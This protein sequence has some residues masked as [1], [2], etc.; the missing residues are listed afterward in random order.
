MILCVS[1]NRPM[2]VCCNAPVFIDGYTTAC[3]IC[4]AC[5]AVLYYTEVTN[6]V[7]EEMCHQKS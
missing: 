7:K 1:Q 6:I 2:S 3:Y 5:Q 4:S